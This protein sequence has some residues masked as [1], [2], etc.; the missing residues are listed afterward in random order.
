MLIAVVCPGKKNIKINSAFC[1]F[2]A[3][4]QN[5]YLLIEFVDFMQTFVLSLLL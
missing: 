1:T 3:L 5:V 2:S 4:P